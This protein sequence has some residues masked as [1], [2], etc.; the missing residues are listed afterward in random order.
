MR[1]ENGDLE[2]NTGL[3]AVLIGDAMRRLFFLDS[4]SG[5]ACMIEGDEISS[6]KSTLGIAAFG[7][8]GVG[9]SIV[10]IMISSCHLQI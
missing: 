1:N 4:H 9:V 5:F 7:F 6:T 10:A 2:G 8:L 3:T